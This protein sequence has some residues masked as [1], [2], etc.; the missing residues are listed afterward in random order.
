ME[1]KNEYRVA[2]AA[3]INLE[4]QVDKLLP[5]QQMHEIKTLF[6]RIGLYDDVVIRLNASTSS[7]VARVD[8]RP[9]SLPISLNISG[10]RYAVAMT[11]TD[12]RNLVVQA[13][14][15]LTHRIYDQEIPDYL[16]D[17]VHIELT[18]RIPVQAGLGGGSA[19]CA[20]AL[21]AMAALINELSCGD[22][23]ITEDT[24][25]DIADDLG[26]DVPF[27]LL[28]K[29]LGDFAYGTGF[30]NELAPAD[31]PNYI[32]QFSHIGLVVAKE[33]L[34][35]ADVYSQFDKMDKLNLQ[36]MLR[37]PNDLQQPALKLYPE[38]AD[39]E[40]IAMNALNAEQVDTNFSTHEFAPEYNRVF[41]TGSGPT[42]VV[43]CR[44]LAEWETV[45]RALDG[46]NQIRQFITIENQ[47]HQ[48]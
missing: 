45:Q 42:W 2:V 14:D 29:K 40:H 44:T 27:L 46:H 5:N 13:I 3:K 16:K 34:S 32:K 12:D 9:T 19:D 11:P 1:M 21:N 24:L 10:D 18:K 25:L 31:A 41:I 17:G 43:L 36:E 23:Q 4:L 26:A 48:L 20:G 37:I 33:G 39:I 35:T 28:P 6:W 7:L 8:L 47:H 15:F 22:V 30:G 38:I